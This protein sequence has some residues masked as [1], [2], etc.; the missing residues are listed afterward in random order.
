MG[1]GHGVRRKNHKQ[2]FTELQE[3]ALA[4]ARR[5]EMMMKVKGTL[6]FGLSHRFIVAGVIWAVTTDN[7]LLEITKCTN[8]P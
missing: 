4:C 3:M 7:T 1:S 6:G 5:T 8:G 2:I